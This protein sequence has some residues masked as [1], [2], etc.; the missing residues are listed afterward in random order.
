MRLVVVLLVIGLLL[1]VSPDILGQEISKLPYHVKAQFAGDIGLVALGAGRSFFKEKLETDLFL[2][3]LPKKIGGQQLFTLALKGTY[4]PVKPIQIKSVDWQPVRT[5]V[6]VAYTFGDE[7]F[8][9][10]PRD[11]YPKSYYGFPTAV[12]LYYF[13]GGQVN[14]NR[15]EKLNK[16]GAYYEVGSNLEYIISYAQ[17]PAY[18]SFGK[19]FN[20]DL[21]IRVKLAP[22]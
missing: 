18:L 13:L 17:N 14:F 9:F 21:G 19:I 10:E 3:Y 2:G 12:H 15:V 20:L 16:I 4:T 11:K 6:H 1:Q 7:Y 5:G 8:M 22:N